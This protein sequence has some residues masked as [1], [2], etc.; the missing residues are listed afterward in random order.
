MSINI[1][2]FINAISNLPLFQCYTKD[3][4]KVFFDN[5]QYRIKQ[6]EKGQIIHFQHERCNAVDI[7]LKGRVAVQMLDENGKVLTI[8]VFVQT[9][10]IGANLI[11]SSRNAYPMTVISES[12]SVI[13]HVYR[14]LILKLCSG[15]TCFMTEMLK[16][17]SDRSLVLTDKINAI[18]LKTIRQRI[19][20]FLTFEY[21]LQKNTVIKL[22]I[23]KKDLAERLG[24]QRTSLSRELAK[25]KKDGLLDFNIG[26]LTI[27]NIKID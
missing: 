15:S 27:L 20:D 22:D 12:D 25:M 11:F 7:I 18:S 17:I 9:D 1:E 4:L 8:N 13:L 19:I 10:I 6:Y 24:I 21:H 3:E 2:S 16:E 14:E 5:S 23:S 26:T